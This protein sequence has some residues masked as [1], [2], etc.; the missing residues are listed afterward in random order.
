[1]RR[2]PR[3]ALAGLGLAAAFTLSACANP[4]DSLV[5]NVVSGGV[6]NLIENELGGD[7]DINIPGSGGSASLPASWPS[8]VPTPAGDVI[9]SLGTPGNWSATILVPSQAVVDQAF[10]DLESAGYTL[11]TEADF[12]GLIS[13]VYDT[14]TRTV[15][16]GV[17][18][19][20]GVDGINV[21]FTIID[22]EP[23]G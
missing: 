10:A 12:G 20:E 13:K 15:T 18:S 11:T 19:E 9:F 4:L 17:I 8:D 3:F 22:K 16:I 14:D 1:M 21:Q 6:E 23:Q 7:V 5:E 2:T